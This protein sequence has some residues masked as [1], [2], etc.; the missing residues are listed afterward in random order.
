MSYLTNAAWSPTRAG[1]FLTAKMD[2][3]VDIW[4]YLHKQNDPTLS[5]QVS[6]YDIRALDFHGSGRFVAV[7]DGEGTTTLLQLSP[8]LSEMQ[9]QER[10]TIGAMFEREQKR[11]KM[12]ETRARE[13]KNQSKIQAEMVS[14]QL[15]D[16]AEVSEE[17]L[18]QAERAFYD[19]VRQAEEEQ[20]ALGGGESSV[21]EY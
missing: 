12:L 7:G 16:I 5:L 9:N 2:G 13:L 21:Q 11:E 17:Q 3:T 4:D 14:S 8:G 6:D 1:V 20:K 15:D 10:Q 18:R 19:A